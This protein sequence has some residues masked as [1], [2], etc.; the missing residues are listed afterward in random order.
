MSVPSSADPQAGSERF[1]DEV[2]ERLAEFA[3]LLTRW[4]GRV[5]LVSASSLPVLRQRHIL[6]SAQL[7]EHAPE[8]ARTWVDLGTGGGFPGLVVSILQS[9]ASTPVHM[10]FIESDQRKAVFL[11]QAVRVLGLEAEVISSRIEDTPALSADVV[12]ARAL[13]PLPVLLGLASRHLAVGGIT[14]FLKGAG[15]ASEMEAARR[16]WT[17]DVEMRQSRTDPEGTVLKMQRL[18]HVG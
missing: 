17:F 10:I 13:A 3:A 7:L 9:S 14:L 6:D 18:R 1:P 8:S 12:S 11:R 16:L 5:N 2:E 15:V 4:N